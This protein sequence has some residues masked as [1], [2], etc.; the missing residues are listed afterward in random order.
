M[1]IHL[2]TI[3]TLADANTADDLRSVAQQGDDFVV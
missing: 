2:L 3:V 1:L